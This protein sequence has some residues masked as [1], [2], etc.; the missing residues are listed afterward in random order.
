MGSF[1]LVIL[2]VVNFGIS[3]W[4]AYAAGKA[5]YPSLAEGGW[6]RL[7]VWSVAIMSALGFTYVFMF[8][9]GAGAVA[10]DISAHS[11]P[12]QHLWFTEEMINGYASL[13][14][15]LVWPGIVGSGLVMTIHSWK[16]ARAEGGAR[17]YMV[18]GYN[19]FAQAWNVIDGI[20]FLPDAFGKVGG[21]F[22]G[23]S[24]NKGSLVLLMI[25]LVSLVAGILLTRLILLSSARAT[26]QRWGYYNVGE[27]YGGGSRKAPD[28]YAE[29]Y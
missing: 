5:W 27:A 10:W 29:G 25:L 3:W 28:R 13:A 21:L 1:L 24:K 8:I 18:A 14:Y 2:L 4:N 12:G 20:R 6:I 23:D 11:G 16:V 19:T 22:K 7:V 17:N 9:G 26:M 15:I